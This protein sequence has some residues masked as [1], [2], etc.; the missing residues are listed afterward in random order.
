M[1]GNNHLVLFWSGVRSFF[2]RTGKIAFNFRRAIVSG[3]VRRWRISLAV[4]SFLLMAGLCFT[5]FVGMIAGSIGRDNERFPFP[6]I[7][8]VAN[9][10]KVRLDAQAVIVPAKPG[11][12]KFQTTHVPIVGKVVQ[13][14]RS[15]RPG[16]GGALT[17]ANGYI[18]AIS[19]EGKMHAVTLEQR[20]IEL[21]ISPPDQGYDEYVLASEKDEYADWSFNTSEF[22][23][24][25]V[26]YLEA[27]DQPALLVSY[28]RYD[29]DRACFS[30]RI[31]IARL[32]APF[33]PDTV[34]IDSDDWEIFFE[35]SP[36][37]PLVQ[38]MNAMSGNMAGGRMVFDDAARLIYLT[39][40]SYGL[41]GNSGPK[42]PLNPEYPPVPQMDEAGYGR[43]VA[44]S[45]DSLVSHHVSK[46]QRNP[47]G[48]AID[49]EARIWTVEHGPRGGDELNRIEEGANYGWPYKSD[50]TAYNGL[51]LK[52][53][54]A[55]PDQDV[56]VEPVLAW[57]PSIGPGGLAVIDGFHPEWDGD[58]LVGTLSQHKLVRI[59][60]KDERVLYTED[61]EIGLG[62]RIR[63][64]LQH[65]ESA[66][67][68]LTDD[69]EVLILRAV[70]GGMVTEYVER[71]IAR[72][73]DAPNRIKQR[74]RTELEA[75]QQCHSLTSGEHRAGPSLGA[76]YQRE[77]GS[78]KFGNYSDALKS[79]NEIWTRERLMRYLENP[80][81]VYPGTIMIAPG[82]QDPELREAI[83]DVLISLDSYD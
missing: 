3:V 58:L 5:L 30:N 60:I 18:L 73:L 67:V 8:S 61:I 52:Q 19:N 77:V 43:V 23:F 22:R 46:G 21:K 39:S 13:L 32:D 53:L 66:I 72:E 59:R 74:V 48:I 27:F 65:S 11:E 4:F 12:I 40:G 75:C 37:L 50:G 44:I 35:T 31:D 33:E 6:L 25:D 54:N 28:S 16:T 51:A 20:V 71:Y 64:V 7:D 57:V 55:A 81:A 34:E 10:I 78:S 2:L 68:L 83:V 45:I 38:E 26:L 42:N 24:N 70:E 41:D 76:V 79:S 14:P 15:A 62:R 49:Q 69:R 47:Q 17:E 63:Y 29:P 56:Y 9:H 80:T 82:V 1:H 36:C